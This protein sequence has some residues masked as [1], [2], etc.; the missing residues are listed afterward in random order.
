MNCPNCGFENHVDDAE[1]CQECGTYLINNCSNPHCNLNNGDNV[2]IPN[3]AK[4]C[5]YCGVESTFKEQGF[6][7]K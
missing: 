2:P 4:F 7:D 3:D 1:F 6:F 5:P